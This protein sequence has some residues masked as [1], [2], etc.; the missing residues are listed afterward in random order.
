MALMPQLVTL[1][2]RT[3]KR[4][5]VKFDANDYFLEPGENQVPKILVGFAK[6]QCILMGSE[7]EINP[8]DFQSLV[9]VK[10]KDDC[11]PLEQDEDQPTRVRLENIVGEGVKIIK[12]GKKARS[13]FEAQV[14]GSSILNE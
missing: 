9:G 14:P 12:R 4:L 13:N 8:K 1:V 3:S 2:N 10:G 6:N 7:D 11:S 5:T